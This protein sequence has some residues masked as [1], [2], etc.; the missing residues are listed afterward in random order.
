MER[1]SWYLNKCM[2]V[3]QVGQQ[4]SLRLEFRL[5]LRQSAKTVISERGMSNITSLPITDK[6]TGLSLSKKRKRGQEKSL[7]LNSCKAV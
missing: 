2:F 5:E 3:H 7:Q 6:I 1:L 4:R